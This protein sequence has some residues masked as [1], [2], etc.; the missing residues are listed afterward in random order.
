MISYFGLEKETYALAIPAEVTALVL[1]DHEGV[2]HVMIPG[3]GF[4]SI[5]KE[6]LPSKRPRLSQLHRDVDDDVTP[7]SS[8]L[9]SL[10]FSIPTADPETLVQ[11]TDLL[12][13]AGGMTL[14]SLRLSVPGFNEDLVRT[15]LEKCPNIEHLSLT[16]GSLQSLELIQ[17]AVATGK[18]LRSLEL[19]GMSIP[20]S[21][22]N[23]F[24]SKTLRKTTP[25]ATSTTTT[26]EPSVIT[27]LRI[28]KAW[29]GG[30]DDSTLDTI[31]RIVADSPSIEYL[32][33]FIQ[34]P[35]QSAYR[36]IAERY[37]GRSY[38]VVRDPLGP[39]ERVAFLSALHHLE[40]LSGGAALTD[41]LKALV[42]LW[43][44]NQSHAGSCATANPESSHTPCR[45]RTVEPWSIFS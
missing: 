14:T 31:E 26:P 1:D 12:E 7:T 30:L 25:A 6:A 44:H 36:R 9:K 8:L 13:N 19:S 45:Q 35:D 2:V 34:Q 17:D 39:S 11:L 21:V 4:C 42:C 40:H 43:R 41:E 3:R 37:N 24:L 32:H 27:Q 29:P 20:P 28:G 16:G 33:Y 38:G 23:T 10:S 15:A 18:P 5:S 22:L